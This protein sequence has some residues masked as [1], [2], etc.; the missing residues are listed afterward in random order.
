VTGIFVASCCEQSG[1]NLYSRN[2]QYM[3]LHHIIHL[4]T[5]THESLHVFSEK[6]RRV[7]GGLL[8][9]IHKSKC[10]T[11]RDKCVETNKTAV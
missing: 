8:C 11:R 10:I 6:L 1:T 9:M 7:F 2:E 3:L 4:R 5:R